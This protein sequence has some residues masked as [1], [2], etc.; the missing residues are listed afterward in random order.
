MSLCRHVCM[1]V[2]MYHGRYLN[3][4]NHPNFTV[5]S[6]TKHHLLDE[7]D[8][9]WWLPRCPVVLEYL[10]TFTPNV[11]VGKSSRTMVRIRVIEFTVLLL[12]SYD[13]WLVVSSWNTWKI[14]TL[15]KNMK[16][17]K[18]STLK[19]IWVRQIA[20]LV[21]MNKKNSSPPF[22][23]WIAVLSYTLMSMDDL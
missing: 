15:W 13:L 3:N 6:K 4:R 19:K 22:T 17:M 7:L 1:H 5:K 16:H 12:L 18:L 11:N 2:G 10:P 9:Y 8:D 23:H 14:W 20:W 21:P